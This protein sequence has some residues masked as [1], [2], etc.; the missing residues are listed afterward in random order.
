MNGSTDIWTMGELLAEVMRPERDQP[1]GQVGPFLG[2]YPSGAPGIFID[3]VARLGRSAGIISAVGQDPFGAAIVERLARDGV[4]T[5]HVETIAGRA[6]GVA[7]VAYAADGSREFLFHWDGTPAVM[8]G[9]P[10]RT[11]ADGTRFFHVMG[12]S[13]MASQPFRERLLETMAMFAE[14][15][16]RITFDPNV[17]LEL[18]GREAVRALV[19]PVLRACSI[20]LPGREELLMLSGETS[21]D[22]AAASLLRRYPLEM[23]AL[24]LGRQGCRVYAKDGRIDVPAFAI[25]EVDPTGAGDCFDAG[26]L[27]G[28][29]DGLP[30][31]EA[32]RYGAAVGALGAA[33]F[34]PMEGDISQASVAALMHRRSGAGSG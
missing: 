15:G 20:L 2:P 21:L 10:S 26:F 27:C 11:I 29:L 19:E 34:G 3:T 17:R 24:K 16:A 1:L 8:A 5:D 23:I 30:P 6:T 7:F 22:A 9:V 13:L 32:A 14:A 33:A 28:L 12:C 18:A 25:D 31:G 4:R